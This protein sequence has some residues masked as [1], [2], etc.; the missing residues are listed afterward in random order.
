MYVDAYSHSVVD[1]VDIVCLIQC[2]SNARIEADIAFSRVVNDRFYL[3]QYLCI[4]DTPDRIT[5]N[6]A[7]GSQKIVQ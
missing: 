4:M 7:F 6:E 2:N 1:L 5:Q 3:V